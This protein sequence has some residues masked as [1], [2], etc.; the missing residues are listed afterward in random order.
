MDDKITYEI[1]ATR[2]LTLLLRA[3]HEE[4]VRGTRWANSERIEVALEAADAVFN[5]RLMKECDVVAV[6]ESLTSGKIQPHV[7]G[8]VRVSEMRKALADG[9]AT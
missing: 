9:N 8:Y 6:Y 7:I 1:R 5:E 2:A 3:M 4:K